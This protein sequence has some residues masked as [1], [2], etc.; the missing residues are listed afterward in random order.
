MLALGISQIAS[1]NHCFTESSPSKW[2]MGKF[3]YLML[4]YC[5]ENLEQWCIYG[6]FLVNVNGE[7][8]LNPFRSLPVL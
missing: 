5:L 3:M 2:K 1:L 7:S 8:I 4:C 6:N